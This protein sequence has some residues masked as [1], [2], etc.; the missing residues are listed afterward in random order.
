MKTFNLKEQ[1]ILEYI[2][3][4]RNSNTFVLANVFNQ[5][6]DRTGVSFNVD[7]GEIRY[8]CNW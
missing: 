7:T 6:L 4:N 5:W 8:D 1:K 3:Y 2:V